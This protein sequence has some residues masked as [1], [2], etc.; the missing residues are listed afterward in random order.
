MLQPLPYVRA[1][2][3]IEWSKKRYCIENG[4]TIGFIKPGMRKGSGGGSVGRAVASNSRDPQF[5][6]HHRQ[7]FIYQLYNTNIV[8]ETKVK[9]KRPGMAHL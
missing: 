4:T 8:E 2:I 7:N 3:C 9:K 6:S 5:E 1:I